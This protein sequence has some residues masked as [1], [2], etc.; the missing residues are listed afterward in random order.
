MP[1]HQALPFK[2]LGNNFHVEMCVT[3][4]SPDT[5]IS[6]MLIRNIFHFQFNRSQTLIQ[7]KE[8]NKIRRH[9]N[10]LLYWLPR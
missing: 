3:I 1:L 4:T 5:S 7:P 10:N 2:L 8:H 6:N 9:P